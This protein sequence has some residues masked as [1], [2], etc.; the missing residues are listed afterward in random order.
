MSQIIIYKCTSEYIV[1]EIIYH[2][3]SRI[4]KNNTTLNKTKYL[5]RYLNHLKHAP[6]CSASVLVVAFCSCSLL[7]FQGWGCFRNGVIYPLR[8]KHAKPTQTDRFLLLWTHSLPVMPRSIEG[9]FYTLDH[10]ESVKNHN[11]KNKNNIRLRLL[12]FHLRKSRN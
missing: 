4:T 3:N 9:C 2:G 7:Q 12:F 6:F 5:N 1:I 10:N 8:K 11:L